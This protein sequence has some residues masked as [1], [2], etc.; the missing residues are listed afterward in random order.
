MSKPAEEM[1]TTLSQEKTPESSVDA[2][3]E[4][5]ALLAGENEPE[6]KDTEEEETPSKAS[7][8]DDDEISNEEEA[9]DD[10]EEGKDTELST[11]AEDEQTWETVLGVEDG[12]LSYNEDGDINGINVKVDGETSTISMTDL[13][14]GFQTSK[15]VTQRSQTLADE[16][17]AFDDQIGKTE[18]MYASKLSSVDAL[19]KHFEKQLISEYDGINWDELRSKDPAEYAAARQD[20]S[21]KAGELQKIQE[22]INNDIAT[23]N[24]ESQTKQIQQNQEYVKTQYELMITNNPEWS[25][26]KVRN[27]AKTSYK[28]FV[29][30]QYGFQ[31]SEFDS[32]FDARLIELIKDAKSYREGLKV[33]DKKKQKTVPKFQKSRGTSRKVVSKLDKLTAASQKAHGA[34]KRDLQTSAVAELLIGT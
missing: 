32:V 11:I 28:N 10:K 3:D 13:I 34:S 30:E 6:S 8:T 15:S 33:A 2:T 29:S 20:F 9:E 17:K 14:A 12:K 27:E 18:Q 4:I 7:K 16:K 26:E 23:T 5:A 19:T 24:Q 21:T 1:S 31:D 25:D 22:A